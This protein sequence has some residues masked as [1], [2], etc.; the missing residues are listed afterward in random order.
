[1][2][3][4]RFERNDMHWMYFLS[5][6]DDLSVMARYIEPTAANM[7]IFSI[8][9]TRLLIAACAEVDV[10]MKQIAKAHLGRKAENLGECRI[11]ITN[12][13]PALAI[14]TANIPRYGLTFAPWTSWS[15]GQ[16]PQWWSGYNLVKHQRTENYSLASLANVLEALA[17]LFI[18]LLVYLRLKGIDIIMPATRLF[19]PTA[20]LGSY[21]ASPEGHLIDLRTGKP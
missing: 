15:T 7:G 4:A 9:C 10:V 13:H 11:A 2:T 6:E 17:G 16:Q 3:A 1:M 19:H 14:A 8:E 5:L 18:G 12:N 21:C 20:A